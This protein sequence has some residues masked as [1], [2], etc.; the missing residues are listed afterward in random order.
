MGAWGLGFMDLHR[1]EGVKV[2]WIYCW[3]V[4]ALRIWRLSILEGQVLFCA[5][6]YDEDYVAVDEYTQVNTGVH[7]F[8]NSHLIQDMC[9]Q[10]GK[11]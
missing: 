10:D 4:L 7:T 3:R 8:G 2:L 9:L 5:S 1:V 6:L 11:G